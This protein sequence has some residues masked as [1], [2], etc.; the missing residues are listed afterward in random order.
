MKMVRSKVVS[1]NFILKKNLKPSRGLS[2]YKKEMQYVYFPA[3]KKKHEKQSVICDSNW[4][5]EWVCGRKM[6]TNCFGLSI[7]RYLNTAK[8]TIAG[9]HATIL[10]RH[11]NL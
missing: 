7:S 2:M 5:K 9:L 1:T 4:E 8:K 10:L 11:Q 6:N 3:E